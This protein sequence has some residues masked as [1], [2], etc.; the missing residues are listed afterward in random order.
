MHNLFGPVPIW[1]SDNCCSWDSFQRD[2]SRCGG[3]RHQRVPASSGRL[4]AVDVGRAR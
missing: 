4:G 2:R 3:G 1:V